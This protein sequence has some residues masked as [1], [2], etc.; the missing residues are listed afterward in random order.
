MN[1]NRMSAPMVGAPGAPA[2]STGRTGDPPAPPGWIRAT[3]R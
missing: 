1:R 2:E 3:A